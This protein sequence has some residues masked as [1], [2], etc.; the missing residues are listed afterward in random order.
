MD[1]ARPRL[2]LR[3]S[4]RLPEGSGT[5]SPGCTKNDAAGH[6]AAYEEEW[7]TETGAMPWEPSQSFAR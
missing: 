2:P 1:N 6:G 4:N 7:W 3:V 5:L